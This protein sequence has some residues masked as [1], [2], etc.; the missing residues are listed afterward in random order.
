MKMFVM[1]GAFGFFGLH[2]IMWFIRSLIERVRSGPEARPQPQATS[3]KRFTMVNRI[4]HAFVILTFFG[5]TA[6]GLPL[7]F[8]DHYWSGP[9]IGIFGGVWSAGIL[10]RIFAV[11]LVMNFVV[12]FAGLFISALRCRRKHDSLLRNWLTGP[13]SM[14]PRWKDITDCWGMMRWFMGGK[15]PTFDRFTYWEKFDYWAEIGGSGI[16]GVSGLLLWFPEIASTIFPGWI[17][18]VAMVVHGYEALLAICFIFTIHFFNAH[19]RFEKFPVDDVMFT[20]SLP[21]EEFKHERGEQYERLIK[22]G[23]FEE[24]RVKSPPRWQRPLAV[25]VG[26]LAMVIGTTLV[27][28]IVMSGL[29]NLNRM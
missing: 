10:H 5:L 12:H 19:L 7:V 6:T 14:L 18:N 23:R 15:K 8:S 25:T 3:I 9:L 13:N 4:N 24:L 1:S 29:E 28:L 17:F 20:G 2:T 16:I 26:I 22:T 21:E 11:M 27:V